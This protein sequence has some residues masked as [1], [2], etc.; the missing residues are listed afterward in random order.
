[1]TNGSRGNL[2]DDPAEGLDLLA[3]TDLMA[4]LG[5]KPEYRSPKPAFTVPQYL[6]K[7]GY[8]IVPVPVY[9]PDVTEILGQPVYRAVAEIGEPID[10]VVV[11]R[12]AHDIPAHVPD[13]ITAKPRAV[14]FQLG[15]TNDDAARALTD[16]GILVVQDRCTAI[17]H[18]R[19][20]SIR[21]ASNGE[22]TS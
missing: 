6:Q 14:W 22:R 12:R 18:R 10:M 4:V 8:R 16:A 9:Y 2:V 1:M 20:E 7:Q 13:L 19:L 5:I 17:E 15:I 21:P 11:F 3:K